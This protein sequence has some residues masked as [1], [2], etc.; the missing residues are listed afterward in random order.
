MKGIESGA[1]V[2]RVLRAGLGRLIN[3]ALACVLASASAA[4]QQTAKVPFPADPLES[5]PALAP[6]T[7]ARSSEMVDVVQRYAADQQALG[8]RYDA[9]D[10]PEQ[11]ARMRGFYIAW[12]TRLRAL[13]FGRM[14]QEGKIDY[15]LLDNHLR[16]QLELADRQDTM[17]AEILPLLPFNDALLRLHDA[18]RDL[19]TIN[20]QATA[21]QVATFAAQIDS[22]RTLLEP[23]RCTAPA[24]TLLVML[25]GSYSLPEEFQSEGFV[26]IARAQHLAADLRLVDAHVRYYQ[27]R[28][29][30]DRLAED[31]IRPARAQ[32]YRQIWLVGISIGAVGAMLYAD[33]HPDDVDGVVLIAPYLGTQLT[34]DEIKR[35]GGLARWPSPEVK[36][37]DID[38]IL[39]HWLQAQ[40]ST[41]STARKLPLFLGYGDDDRFRYNDEVLRAALPA[42]RVF[43]APGGHD[44]PAWR[45]VWERIA[46]VLPVPTDRNCAAG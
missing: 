15:V 12:R 8:R 46:R 10:S 39:W 42:S 18:R 37:D 2:G 7:A 14:S 40:T 41:E 9:G 25:P 21:K 26:K 19:E 6:M 34:A 29:V 16:Y 36:P 20:P 17:R 38:T 27:N 24:G 1:Q 5:V 35:A 22:L 44:W 32:G 13:D 23:A 28:S 4:A 3:L 11:R 43:T 31:V 45:T 30:I 33:A